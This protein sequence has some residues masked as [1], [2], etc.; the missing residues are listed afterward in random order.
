MLASRREEKDP[1]RGW[2]AEGQAAQDP[3]RNLA[4]GFW[5]RAREGSHRSFAAEWLGP[6]CFIRAAEA[7]V[8][9]TGKSYWASPV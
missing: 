7:A 2:E 3:A 4:C 6:I 5:S 1:G 9:G 8:G